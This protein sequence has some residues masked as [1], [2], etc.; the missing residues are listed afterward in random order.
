MT[1]SEKGWLVRQDAERKGWQVRQDAE[2]QG[3]MVRQEER[4]RQA[5]HTRKNPIRHGI[6][7]R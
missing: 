2:R 5:S 1:R 3:W 7:T 6:H 4:D